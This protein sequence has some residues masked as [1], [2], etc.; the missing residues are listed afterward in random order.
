V[1]F[2]SAPLTVYDATYREHVL[3]ISAK[4]ARLGVDSVTDVVSFY[5]ISDESL[6]SAGRH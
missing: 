1:I 2:R 5:G 4:I 3:E 6:V